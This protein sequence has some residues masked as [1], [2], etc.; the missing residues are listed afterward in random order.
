MNTKLTLSLD[1]ETIERA[2]KSARRRRI[3]LSRLVAR[4]FDF[5]GKVDRPPEEDELPPLTRSLWGVIE[6]AEANEDGYLKH[7]D[8]KYR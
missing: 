3:S 1:E 4:Y 7:L 6:G 5:M 8:E 2:K